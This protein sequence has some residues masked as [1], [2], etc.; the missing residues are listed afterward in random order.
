MTPVESEVDSSCNRQF[1]KLSLL[2][3]FHM[4]HAAAPGRVD[5]RV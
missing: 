5:T 4:K 3:V 1:V 2:K